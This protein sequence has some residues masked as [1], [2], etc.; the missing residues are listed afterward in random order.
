MTKIIFILSAMLQTFISVIGNENG[1]LLYP[2]STGHN[3]DDKYSSLV[4]P[5]LWYNNIW[6]PGLT[7]TAKYQLGPAGQIMVHKPGI[8]TITA[9]APGADFSDAIVQDS[10]ITI[11]LNKQYNRS[12]KIYNATAASVAYPIAAAELETG[13]KEVAKAW[14][15]SGV[16]E[17]IETTSIIVSDNILT[18]VAADTVFDQIVADRQKLVETGVTPDVIIVSPSAYAF[19]LKSDE[20]QRVG[21]IG[22]NA[23][24][25]GVVGYVAG[26]KVVEYEALDTAAVDGQTIGGITWASGDELEYAMYDHDAFSIVTSVDM[27]R[28]KDSERFNGTL[29]QI[30]MVSGFKLTNPARALLKFHDTSAT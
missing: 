25:N 20:F 19:L 30:E 17:L 21:I 29:A 23:V 1:N 12:R 26:M 5:N 13:I 18:L 16:T 27:V 14:T 28:V 3:T 6:Q 10:L 2:A 9:T 4:E 22:D 15:K 24:A 7:F 8:A 11:A